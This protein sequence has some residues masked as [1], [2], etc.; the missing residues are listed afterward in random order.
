MR[1]TR[2]PAGEKNTPDPPK[3]A[4]GSAKKVTKNRAWHFLASSAVIEGAIFAPTR[5]ST[6]RICI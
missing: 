3:K 4:T 2:P 1:T 6:V 5:F